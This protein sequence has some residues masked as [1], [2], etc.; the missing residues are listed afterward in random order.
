MIQFIILALLKTTYGFGTTESTIPLG[1]MLLFVMIGYLISSQIMDRLKIKRGL[2]IGSLA[3][4]MAPLFFLFL[5]PYLAF[6]QNIVAL[7]LFIGLFGLGT[8]MATPT[9]LTLITDLAPTGETGTELA[10]FQGV[11]NFNYV[12]ANFM[13]GYLWELG[14]L[15]LTMLGAMLVVLVGLVFVL[16]GVRRSALEERGIKSR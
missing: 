6:M 5:T 15:A 2:L 1:I 3:V 7:V 16:V 13:S 4:T 11:L 9:Y 10:V 14:A 8:G 12:I